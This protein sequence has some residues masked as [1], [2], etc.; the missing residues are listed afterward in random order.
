[1]KTPAGPSIEALE[2]LRTDCESLCRQCALIDFDGKPL[3][4]VLGSEI[5]GDKNVERIGGCTT[6]LLDILARPSI[7]SRGQWCGRGPAL[8]INEKMMW[9]IAV[10]QCGT[11][12]L[13]VFPKFKSLCLSV[14]LHEAA[15]LAVDGTARQDISP[16]AAEYVS[17]KTLRAFRVALTETTATREERRSDREH[18]DA[19]W[20][21]AILHLHHRACATNYWP[22]LAMQLDVVADLELYG[23]SPVW[24]FERAIGDEPARLIGLSIA[25]ILASEPPGEFS[26]LYTADTDRLKGLQ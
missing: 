15:H 11:T 13:P 4:V 14:A 25:E 6:S 12:S 1:V 8:M 26:K 17:T 10:E 22:L 18:H 9:Q 2:E 20:I 21:R 3:Y 16:E 23:L 19:K 5:I 24:K 7:E